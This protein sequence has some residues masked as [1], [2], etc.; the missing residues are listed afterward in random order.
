MKSLEQQFHDIGLKLLKQQEQE[1][2]LE[3]EKL[4]KDLTDTNY[5]IIK[6]HY[7]YDEFNYDERMSKDYSPRLLLNYLIDYWRKCYG[8]TVGLKILNENANL[9]YW[10][11]YNGY[12]LL[13]DYED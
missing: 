8:L 4:L 6:G 3:L 9:I 13:A 5:E 2:E 11:D 12:E 7:G 10:V 1:A